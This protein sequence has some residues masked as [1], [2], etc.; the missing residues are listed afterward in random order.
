MSK[1]KE[2][3]ES[4]ATKLRK[5]DDQNELIKELDGHFEDITFFLEVMGAM[6]VVSDV[7]QRKLLKIRRDILRIQSDILKE[8][9]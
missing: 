8:R 9:K 2:V 4:E 7:N 1:L 3:L 6:P 5:A